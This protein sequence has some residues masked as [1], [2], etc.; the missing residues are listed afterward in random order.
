MGRRVRPEG[1]GLAPPDNAR[2][3]RLPFT[4][5]VSGMRL[6]LLSDVHRGARARE[7]RSGTVNPTLALLLSN[8]FPG[9]LA[10]EHRADLERSGLTDETLQAQAIVR[11]RPI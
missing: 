9:D 6:F 8:L 4:A 3:G 7:G 2:D 5:T 10:P 11:C 1:A